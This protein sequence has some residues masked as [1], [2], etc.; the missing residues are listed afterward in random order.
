[1]SE[2]PDVTLDFFSF[3]RIETSTAEGRDSHQPRPFLRP[4]FLP[5]SCIDMPSPPRA[6]LAAA[7]ALALAS[8]A[9]GS[10]VVQKAERDVSFSC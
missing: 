4:V 1:M 3:P 10:L 7:L 6:A 2:K 5:N 9:A 8:A